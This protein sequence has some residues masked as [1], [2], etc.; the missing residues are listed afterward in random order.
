M[1][2]FAD[3]QVIVNGKGLLQI[4]E[5]IEYQAQW[6]SD[7]NRLGVQL[8]W[9]P[10]SPDLMDILLTLMG[11]PEDES[12]EDEDGFCRDWL[13]MGPEDND[14]PTP[15]EYLDWLWEQKRIVFP[16]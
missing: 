8:D 11:F 16:E 2:Q 14:H 15:R 1:E 13:S 5:Y 12:M 4:L 7:L 9:G 6:E 10:G 3:S